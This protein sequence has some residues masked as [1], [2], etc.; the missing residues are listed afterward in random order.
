MR[1]G[2][3]PFGAA[4]AFLLMTTTLLLTATSG[5]WMHRRFRR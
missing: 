4:V 5:Y 3:W 2:N 1:L